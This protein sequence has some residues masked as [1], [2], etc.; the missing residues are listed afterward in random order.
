M[1]VNIYLI[2]AQL[3]AGIYLAGVGYKLIPDPGKKGS[4][5]NKEHFD[6]SRTIFKYAGIGAIT[7]S[8]ILSVF[9]YY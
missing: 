8:F 6:K 4:L 2:L 9:L 7:Y 1:S 3:I 5:K